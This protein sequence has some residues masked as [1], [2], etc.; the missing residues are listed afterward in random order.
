MKG[1]DIENLNIDVQLPIKPFLSKC[2]HYILKDENGK[3]YILACAVNNLSI[4]KLKH[5]IKMQSVLKDTY[6]DYL[7]FNPVL[8]YGELN[9]SKYYGKYYALYPYIENITHYSNIEPD[10]FIKL[11]KEKSK[12]YDMT[13]E[14]I[15][16][17]IDSFL[18]V[19]P[20]KIVNNSEIQNL[21]LE[22]KKELLTLQT[23]EI[24]DEH[25]DFAPV[26][27]M[28][29]SDKIYMLDFEIAK[30][31]Q[32]IGYDMYH[33]YKKQGLEE[34]FKDIIP[35]YKINKLKFRIYTN[36]ILSY[37]YSA[38]NFGE[39]C[40]EP[41]IKISDN[42]IEI[43]E[44]REKTSINYKNKKCITLDLKNVSISYHSI[45]MI[46]LLLQEKYGK[47]IEIINSA[48]KLFSF[49]NQNTLSTTIPNMR[50]GGISMLDTNKKITKKNKAGA[51]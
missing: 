35:Y 49:S 25:S 4:K 26:N 8:S 40:C 43:T 50:G 20:D 39:D 41:L 21:F 32:V 27:I 6:G 7:S 11:Y 22:F 2:I 10:F 9:Q 17:I 31:F 30:A 42:T 23:V 3:K 36:P 18:E 24:I 15:N 51:Y 29:A 13:E 5:S 44:D 28:R 16:K 1:I 14:A 46:I 37:D 12:K 45:L 47:S 34:K 48:I 19:Y 33:Y 38:T